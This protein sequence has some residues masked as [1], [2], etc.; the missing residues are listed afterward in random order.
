MKNRAVFMQG[1]DNM[2]TKDVPMPKIKEKDVLI[3]VDIVGICGSDVHYYKHGKIG[4]FVVEGE[5]ILGHEAAGEVV[6]VGEQV[7]G[8]TV[9]DRVTM[10]PGKTCG[11]CEFCKG[12][13]Y[14][15]CPDVEFFATPPYHGVLTNY[16]SHP[17]DMC[18]KLPKN[19]SNVEGALVEPLAVGLHASDQGGVKL[20]DTVVIFGTGCIGLMT[21]ISCKAKGAAKI[22]VVD[23]LENRLE[24]AKKVGATDTINAKEVNVL[25]K[26]QELTDGKG[27]EVV[28]DA[29]GAAITVK[30]TVDAVK[31]GGTIVLVGMTP[32]DE[33]EFNFMKLMGKEAE[34]KTVFRYRNLYPIAINAIAS[35]AINIKDIVSHEFDFEQT[36]EAFD[37]V[38]EHASDVVKAVIKIK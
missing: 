12:G 10:E 31:P 13:K 1:T 8:L 25:K 35:G 28:I 14:N 16:V 5:F 37:F 38:A 27:A 24:V 11:K 22:I 34:V 9:G 21:I 2:V 20:G 4:D 26:I 3:K 17:E 30:Q 36:K 23:I 19:V 32:K 6:E 18:F 33:V 29:A 15:L 7:K